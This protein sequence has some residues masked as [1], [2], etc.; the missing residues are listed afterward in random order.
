MAAVIVAAGSAF[1]TAPKQNLDPLY[2]AVYNG[3]NFS[4]ESIPVEGICAANPSHYCEA[5]FAATP[6][7]NQVPTPAELVSMGDI[8]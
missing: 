6:S 7:D 4:W 3:S 5:R 8:Q 1:I 2:K